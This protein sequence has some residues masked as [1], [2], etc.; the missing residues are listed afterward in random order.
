MNHIATIPTT[1]NA[2]SFFPL[3]DPVEIDLLGILIEGGRIFAFVTDGQR[4]RILTP[5]AKVLLSF[6]RFKDF[7]LDEVGVLIS[8]LS[9]KTASA[10]R[11]RLEWEAALEVAFD[12]GLGS[13]AATGGAA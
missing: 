1:A 6:P 12:K 13:G 11:R 7:V 5:K 9:Q 10:R 2:F 4:N 3:P 8:H